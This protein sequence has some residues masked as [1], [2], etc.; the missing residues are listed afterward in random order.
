MLEKIKSKF[1]S[2]KV[3]EYIEKDTVLNIFK[4]NK[5]YQSKFDFKKFSLIIW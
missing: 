5:F 3:L 4:Y 2:K 1:I